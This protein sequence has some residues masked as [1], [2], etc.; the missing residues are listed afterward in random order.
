MNQY[1]TEVELENYEWNIGYADKM[2]F[3][4]SCFTENIGEIMAGLKFQT[5]INP[6]GILYNPMSV[7]NSLRNLMA[8]RKYTEADLFEQNGI[9]GSYDFH[10]RYSAASSAEALSKMNHQL[11]TGHAFLKEADY[12]IITW[13]TAWVYDLKATGKLVANCHKFPEADFKR[14]RLTPGEIVAEFRDL[15]TSLWKFN[16]NLKIL[17][18]VSPIR[19]LKD[20]AN[21]NQLSK[22]TLLL[23]IDRLITGYG[24]QHCHYFPAYEIV[25]DELRDYRFY[26]PDLV[27]LSSVAIDHIWAKFKLKL[28]S[29]EATALSRELEKINKAVQHKPF[30]KDIPDYEKFL[31]KN[32]QK[33]GKLTINFPYL[34]LQ[35]EKKYFEM[36][37]NACKFS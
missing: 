18:T 4:G 31:V 8:K 6:F 37:L 25:M 13:G 20:G 21:G 15:L 23:A 1:Y 16:S 17:F 34:N 22:S 27:H 3:M 9:R 7:A 14:Y 29:E 30:R 10:S 5:L 32:I 24:K 12:L 2:V 36:E 33:I 11:E 35:K 26:D 28:I 19:H